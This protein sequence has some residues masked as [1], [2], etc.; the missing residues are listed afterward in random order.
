MGL[1]LGLLGKFTKKPQKN[2]RKDLGNGIRPAQKS[3]EKTK[4]PVQDA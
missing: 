4:G 2:H 3:H 1:R